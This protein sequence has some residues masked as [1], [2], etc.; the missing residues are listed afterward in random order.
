MEMKSL[1]IG[2]KTYD[3]FNP[4]ASEMNKKLDKT[5][6]TL[7][8]NVNMFGYTLQTEQI[9]LKTGNIDGVVMYSESTEANTVNKPVLSLYG[10][11]ADQAV[12]I[13][14][15]ETPTRPYEA[16]NKKYVDSLYATPNNAP[17][18]FTGAVEATYDGTENVTVNIPSGG[19]EV[20]E[21][22][23]TIE[24]SE[25]IVKTTIS[26]DNNGRP[27]S[28]KKIYIEIKVVPPTNTDITYN[29]TVCCAF[30][31]NDPWGLQKVT[32]GESPKKGE[33]YAILMISGFDSY[34]GKIIPVFVKAPDVQ[35]TANILTNG[36]GT[37]ESRGAF[38]VGTLSDINV[39]A[40]SP[41]H[42]IGIGSYRLSLF[43]GT[44][45]KIYGV[46]A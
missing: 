34:A 15:V 1:T 20:W 24:I 39:P 21:E 16:A 19:S 7:T 2:G 14:N 37:Y 11:D 38:S 6:G 12:T 4:A 31:G 18:T 44:T 23:R 29:A 25:D 45:I 43:A 42:S 46:R 8:G 27:F 28:L 33:P 22:I 10:S 32:L 13:F 3:E 26:T 36:R 9:E 41:C 40:L 30:N 5:G 17:L 35:S